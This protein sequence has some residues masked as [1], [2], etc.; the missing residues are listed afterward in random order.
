MDRRPD[1]H[2]ARWRRLRRHILARDSWTCQACGKLLG[3]AQVDHVVPVVKGGAVFDPAN[4]QAI[5]VSCHIAK[6]RVDKG[7]LPDPEREAWAR[8]VAR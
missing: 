6:T 5:C 2:T 4:L 7:Q 3:M 1:L 8:Y